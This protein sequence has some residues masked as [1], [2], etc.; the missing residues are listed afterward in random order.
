MTIPFWCL[1]GFAGWTVALLLSVGAARGIPVLLGRKRASE[2]TPGVP[3]GS[4]RYWRLNR[5]HLN[6]L[7]NLP[8]FAVLVFMAQ[9]TG[10]EGATMDNLARVI[11]AGR[12]GQSITHISS[13]S[14]TAVLVRFSFFGLQ[15]IS[16]IWMGLHVA[17]RAGA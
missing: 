4:D 14:D 10:V 12:I 7:E 1:L 9:F 15:V 6:C 13:G 8:I 3:H 2:F 11:L 5:A 17:S 16:F